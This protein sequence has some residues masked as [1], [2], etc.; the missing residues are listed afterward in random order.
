MNRHK[1]HGNNAIAHN[2]HLTN[3]S[4]SFFSLAHMKFKRIPGWFVSHENLGKLWVFDVFML[5]CE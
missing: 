1:P 4:P 3:S 2:L 5:G